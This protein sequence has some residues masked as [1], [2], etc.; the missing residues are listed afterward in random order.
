MVIILNKKTVL[1]T[2]ASRGIGAS[3]ANKFAKNNYNIIINYLNSKEK[4]EI[5][6]KELENKYKAECITI[7]ADISKEEDVK[8]MTKIAIDKFKKIDVLVNNAGLAIDTIFIDKTV[9][10]L[11]KILSTNLIGTFLV[12]KY[13][14][15]YMPDNS[16]IINIS[17]TNGIDTVYPYSMDYDASK[18]GVINLTKNLAIEFAPKIRVNSVAPGWVNTDMNK[19]LSKEFKQEETN[20]ILLNR[21]AEPKEIAEV[22]Y[23]LASNKASYINGTT[24]RVDGGIK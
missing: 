24:I 4:A 9:D 18:A 1:I 8:E 20:K 19:E 5:L 21:F 13:I 10:N 22:V 23:F 3:I 16:S 6:K 2:G 7:K 14:S 15:K 12:S 11:K 17:S